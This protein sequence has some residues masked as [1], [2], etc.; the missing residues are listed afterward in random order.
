MAEK[1]TRDTLKCFLTPSRNF[2]AS[3]QQNAFR[4]SS[5]IREMRIRYEIDN[6]FSNGKYKYSISIQNCRIGHSISKSISYLIYK[7]SSF[8]KIYRL[9][10]SLE[11]ANDTNSNKNKALC[12][13]HVCCNSN[14]TKHEQW[15]LSSPL[16]FLPTPEDNPWQCPLFRLL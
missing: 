1:I 11:P 2:C 9:V 10:N 16:S 8:D 3:L 7:L 4:Q 12:I 5:V 14:K 15:A 13:W 6:I